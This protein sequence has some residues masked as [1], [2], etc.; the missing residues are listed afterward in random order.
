[1]CVC[2]CVCVCVDV[3]VCV[4]VCASQC[5]IRLP[6]IINFIIIWIFD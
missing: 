5:L 6:I 3:S 4:C 2:V 1:M